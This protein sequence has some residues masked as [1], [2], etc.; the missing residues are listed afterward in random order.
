[1]DEQ[2]KKLRKQLLTFRWVG[3]GLGGLAFPAPIIGMVAGGGAYGFIA[4]PVLVLGGSDAWSQ[5]SRA[6]QKLKIC[7][8]P[9]TR[10]N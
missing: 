4:V 1:M 5:A 8:R 7:A 9:L 3:I 10:P 6:V 2:L